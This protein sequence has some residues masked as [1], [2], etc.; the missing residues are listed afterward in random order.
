MFKKDV[1]ILFFVVLILLFAFR[2]ISD[3][4]EQVVKNYIAY[5][6]HIPHEKLYVHTDKNT[7]DVGEDIWFRVYGVH[8][9][10]HVPRTPSRVGYGGVVGYTGWVVERG[11]V[12]WGEGCFFCQI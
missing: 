7:Y 3:F 2:G 8:A 6:H 11:E 12:G 9:L 10:T 5:V 4:G 1:C